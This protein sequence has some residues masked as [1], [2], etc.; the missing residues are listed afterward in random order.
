MINAIAYDDYAEVSIYG[1][2]HLD[3]S[4]ELE[5]FKSHIYYK[6]R[7]F[8]TRKNVWVIHNLEKYIGIPYIKTALLDRDKQL[9]LF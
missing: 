6:D 1:E 3:W 2:R 4:V 9:K 8:D 5:R 7:R